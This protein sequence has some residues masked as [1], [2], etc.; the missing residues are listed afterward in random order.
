MG[1]PMGESANP[2]PEP[3]LTKA[4]TAS[5]VILSGGKNLLITYVQSYT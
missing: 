4:K 1:L 3:V 2:R 5:V